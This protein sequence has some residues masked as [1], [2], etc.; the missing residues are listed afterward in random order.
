MANFYI[1]SDDDDEL[2][3]YE[4]EAEGDGDM[5]NLEPGSEDEAAF[6]AEVERQAQQIENDEDPNS[7]PYEFNNEDP[8]AAE[9]SANKLI[10]DREAVLAD[11]AEFALKVTEMHGAGVQTFTSESMTPQHP[12][13]AIFPK[14]VVDARS[15]MLIS[16]YGYLESYFDA[17]VPNVVETEDD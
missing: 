3:N 11:K 1:N 6:V 17:K 7:D 10:I 13:T 5:M 12:S 15:R 4:G 14:D 2:N 8:Y 9:H 16:A